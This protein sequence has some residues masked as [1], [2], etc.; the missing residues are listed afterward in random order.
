M[1]DFMFSDYRGNQLYQ[2]DAERRRAALVRGLIFSDDELA[3]ILATWPPRATAAPRRKVAMAA[4]RQRISM[5]S[6]SGKARSQASPLTA[7]LPAISAPPLSPPCA[8]A[9]R[10][11]RAARGGR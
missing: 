9:R 10:L 7:A 1:F 6:A 3:A 11:R 2:Y 8:S 4:P 5:N